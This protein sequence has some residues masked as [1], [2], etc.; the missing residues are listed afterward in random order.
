VLAVEVVYGFNSGV[1][2]DI[3]GEK[4]VISLKK[5]IL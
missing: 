4:A 2:L 5:T 1:E 3:N